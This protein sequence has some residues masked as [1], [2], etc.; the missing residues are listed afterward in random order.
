MKASLPRNDGKQFSHGMSGDPSHDNSVEK[1][2]PAE[3]MAHPGG[4]SDRDSGWDGRLTNKGL[5][6]Q[7]YNAFVTA[8]PG[9]GAHYELIQRWDDLAELSGIRVTNPRPAWE[10]EA[11]YRAAAAH[12]AP[13]AVELT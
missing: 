7:L 12:T 2:Q 5:V 13:A 9:P 11:E 4:L 3:F 8:L 1:K 6:E 10:V